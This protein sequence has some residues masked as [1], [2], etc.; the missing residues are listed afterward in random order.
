MTLVDRWTRCIL[1][2]AVETT[3]AEATLQRLVDTARQARFYCSDLLAGYRL[4][5]YRPGLYTP[6]P[7]KSET[8]PSKA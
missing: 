5:V 8:S 1:A 7:D 6:M 4:V 2:W 3:R